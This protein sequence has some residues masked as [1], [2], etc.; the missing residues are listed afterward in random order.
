MVS[1]TVTLLLIVGLVFLGREVVRDRIIIEP[2]AVQMDNPKGAL[3]T[4]LAGQELLRY[5][6]LIQRIGAGEWQQFYIDEPS[7]SPVAVEQSATLLAR[8][9]NLKELG[10]PL[11]LTTSIGEIA[12]ALGVRH[13]TIKISIGSRKSPP[14]Y[15]S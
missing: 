10:A 12:S 14:G 4:E 6:A 1:V 2:V 9:I 3:T 11:N 13:P 7:T 8:P 15:I 5:F